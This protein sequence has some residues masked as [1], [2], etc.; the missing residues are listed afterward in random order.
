MYERKCQGESP[1]FAVLKKTGEV[2]VRCQEVVVIRAG[3]NTSLPASVCCTWLLHLKP[4][5]RGF[6]AVVIVSVQGTSRCVVYV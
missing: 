2:D 1:G 6:V 4:E 3:V 5:C